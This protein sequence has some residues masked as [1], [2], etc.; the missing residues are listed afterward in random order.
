MDE[1]DRDRFIASWRKYF[2]GA[3]LPLAVFYTDTRPGDT[4][5]GSGSAGC[6][7]R[8]LSSAR[9]GKTLCFGAGDSLCS[10]AKRYFGFTYETSMPDFEYFLS[11][12]IPD[13]VRGE[14]YKKSPEIV[15]EST[16]RSPSFTAPG[17]YIV[18]KRWDKLSAEDAPIIAVFFADQDVVSGLFTLAN[19]DEVEPDGVVCP[20]GSGCSSIVLHP[21]LELRSERPRCVLGMFDISARPYV[22]ENILTFAVPITKFERMIANMDESFL[23]TDSWK[24]LYG[25]MRK[26]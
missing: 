20:F 4:S 11:Y 2:G 7:V 18:F 5:A 6:V 23:I 25:R 8:V 13:K 14:R 24:E 17:K 12:G 9:E 19:F 21:Y 16:K 1:S 26:G 3:E 15:R 22:G 10:G